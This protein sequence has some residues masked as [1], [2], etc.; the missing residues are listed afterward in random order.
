MEEYL[1]SL[2]YIEL[3]NYEAFNSHLDVLI[4]WAMT[5]KVDKTCTLYKKN[6][7]FINIIGYWQQVSCDCA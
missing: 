6:L 3:K 1:I 5:Y 4:V 2:T 7:P